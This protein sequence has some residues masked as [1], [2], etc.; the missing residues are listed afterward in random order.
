MKV[1]QRWDFFKGTQAT[2]VMIFQSREVMA[3]SMV[4]S[5]L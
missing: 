1:P 4:P 3:E 2:G 5:Y